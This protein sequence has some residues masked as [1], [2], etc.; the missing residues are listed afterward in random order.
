[1]Q[2]ISIINDEISDDIK[3]VVKFLKKISFAMLN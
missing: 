1:M 3:E 2:K